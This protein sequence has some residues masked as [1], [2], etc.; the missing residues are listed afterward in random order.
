MTA[1]SY[2]D[3]KAGPWV[4]WDERTFNHAKTGE[5]VTMKSYLWRYP[6]PWTTT[7]SK[8]EAVRFD[9]RKEANAARLEKF[10]RSRPARRSG[11]ERFDQ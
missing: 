4:V 6:H 2:Y 11:V 7:G 1:R 5:P 10:G 9:T 3:P 8:R